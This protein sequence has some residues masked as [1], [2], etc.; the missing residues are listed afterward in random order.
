MKNTAM[1]LVSLFSVL[2][3][4]DVE[5]KEY[6]G[7]DANGNSCVFEVKSVHFVDNKKHPLNE[8]VEI[9]F[10]GETYFLNHPSLVNMATGEVSFNHDLLQA[11]NSKSTG[12]ESITLIMSH[13]EGNKGPVE[14][15]ISNHNWKN[16]QVSKITCRLNSIRSGAISTFEN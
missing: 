11:V 5:L 6:S 7:K 9:T 14:L 15:I 13:E 2:A 4:A 1:I 10:A 3:I 8:R 12:A 16:N